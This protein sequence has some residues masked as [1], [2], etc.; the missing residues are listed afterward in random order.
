[1]KTKMLSLVMIAATLA[2]CRMLGAPDL[3][4]PRG[5]VSD[6]NTCNPN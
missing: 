6:F 5:R 1:M 2:G 3:H 4:L